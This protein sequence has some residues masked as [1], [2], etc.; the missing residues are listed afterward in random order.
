[1]HSTRCLAAAGTGSNG[2]GTGSILFFAEQ[3]VARPIEEMQPAAGLAVHGFVGAERIVRRGFLRK[4]VLHVHAG[5][6]TFEDEV[7]HAVRQSDD[8]TP[9]RLD[10]YQYDRG[11]AVFS[12]RGEA[13]RVIRPIENRDLSLCGNC[14]QQGRSTGSG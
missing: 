11:F 14:C 2:G 1:V 3:F 10:P 6:W 8:C 5:P 4:P 7:T 13:D 12:G 9:Q